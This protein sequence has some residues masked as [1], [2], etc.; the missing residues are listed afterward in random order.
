M[1]S[2]PPTTCSTASVAPDRGTPTSPLGVYGASSGRRA[3]RARERRRD[4]ASAT[5]GCAARA[6]L[7]RHAAPGRGPRQLVVADSRARTPAAD[8]RQNA[9]VLE[10]KR[11]RR[12]RH[13]TAGRP[14]ARV[15]HGD[16]RARAHERP[17][18]QRA[19]GVPI[20]RRI[21]P[22]ERDGGGIR[23][24]VSKLRPGS[25]SVATWQDAQTRPGSHRR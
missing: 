12:C 24:R 6:Q 14:A 23:A 3:R 25:R 17:A 16:R 4:R 8:R 15:S 5:R 10:S 11:G 1:V 20:Q 13:L 19:H 7:M 18:R 2:T 21:S 9:Q 22:T